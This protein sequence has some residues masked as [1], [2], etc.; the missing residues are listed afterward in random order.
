MSKEPKEQATTRRA[1]PAGLAVAVLLALLTLVHTWPLAAHWNQAIPMC[2]TPRRAGN[3]CPRC[4]ATICSFTIGRGCSPTTSPAPSTFP[5]NPYEFNT[6]LHP[7][8]IALYANF[9]FSLFYLALKPLGALSAYNAV[10]LLTYLLAG[11]AAFAPG[12][13]HA[14]Q[15]PGRPARGP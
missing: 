2:T 13:T 14:G 6:F 12:P 15:L 7:Q 1:W 4:P 9:P 10:V 11:L 5:S 3:W 8:G